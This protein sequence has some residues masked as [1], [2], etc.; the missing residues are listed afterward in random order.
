[1]FPPRTR[2]CDPCAEYARR[3]GDADARAEHRARDL[4]LPRGIARPL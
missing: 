1:M 3:Q 2:G 4:F